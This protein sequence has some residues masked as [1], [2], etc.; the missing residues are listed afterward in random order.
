MAGEILGPRSIIQIVDFFAG[1][2]CY[3]TRL[4]NE[5]VDSS[6]PLRI[7][8]FLGHTFL[9]VSAYLQTLLIQSTS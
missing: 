1:N 8:T 5:Q 6:I 7:I 4:K 3:I 2:D 9:P